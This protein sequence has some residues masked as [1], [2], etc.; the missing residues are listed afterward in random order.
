MHFQFDVAGPSAPPQAAATPPT[1]VPADALELL[2]QILDVQREQL[3]L[4]RA[5][6]AA[7]D[8]GN[9]WRT[10][11]ARWN[12]DYPGLAA[13]CKAVLPQVERALLELMQELTERIGDDGEAIDNEFTLGEFLD[14]YGMKLGQ[15]GTILNLVTPL[16]EAAP[17]PEQTGEAKSNEG[18]G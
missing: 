5:V 18:G 10:F 17:P 9:R 8:G 13:A 7:S 12:A 4:S 1:D 2:R 11:L 3:A 14:R 16:A 6:A 15:L